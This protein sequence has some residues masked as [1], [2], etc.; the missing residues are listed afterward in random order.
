VIPVVICEATRTRAAVACWIDLAVVPS[1][2]TVSLEEV[3][4]VLVAVRVDAAD[5]VD[6]TGVRSLWIGERERSSL[7]VVADRAGL[8]RELE[9]VAGR[10]VSLTRPLPVNLYVEVSQ[11]RCI[12]LG[13]S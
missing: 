6:R 7:W 3:V 9:S 1:V 11:L 5:L 10:L 13:C 12:L 8:V 4:D 2:R